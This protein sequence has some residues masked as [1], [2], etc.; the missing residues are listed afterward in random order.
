MASAIVPSAGSKHIATGCYSRRAPP[1]LSPS[2]TDAD[3]PEGKVTQL[4]EPKVCGEV[5]YF[6]GYDAHKTFTLNT[7]SRPINVQ[8]ASKGWHCLETKSL[9]RLPRQCRGLAFM[10]RDNHRSTS[11][12]LGFILKLKSDQNRLWYTRILE[13]GSISDAQSLAA[14]ELLLGD[15]IRF[16][17]VYTVGLRTCSQPDFDSCCI[18]SADGYLEVRTQPT[19]LY[20][21]NDA[22]NLFEPSQT[23]LSNKRSNLHKRLRVSQVQTTLKK[24]QRTNKKLKESKEHKQEPKTGATQN[25]IT[26]FSRASRVPSGM[27]AVEGSNLKKLLIANPNRKGRKRKSLIPRVLYLTETEHYVIAPGIIGKELNNQTAKKISEKLK[28][29]GKLSLKKGSYQC[30]YLMEVSTTKPLRFSIVDDATFD[31]LCQEGQPEQCFKAGENE[32]LWRYDQRSSLDVEGAIVSWWSQEG[33]LHKF[34]KDHVVQIQSAVGTGFGSRISAFCT[35]LNAYFGPRC[36]DRPKRNPGILSKDN[37]C[38][39]DFQ[40]K[41][42]HSS[43]LLLS[44]IAIEQAGT[45]IQDIAARLNPLYMTFTGRSVSKRNIF[46]S[47][48]SSGIDAARYLPI[49]F[50]NFPHVDSCDI[51]H[52]KAVQYFR[53][54]FLHKLQGHKYSKAAFEN[55]IA[56]L[57]VVQNNTGGLG[58]PTTCGHQVFKGDV[59]GDFMELEA[60]FGMMDFSM[61]I[62]TNTVHH[63]YGWAFRHATLVPFWRNHPNDPNGTVRYCNSANEAEDIIV[64]AW[65]K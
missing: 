52:S 27:D 22:K 10:F 30:I 1:F 9:Q 53:D 65:G 49:G 37:I 47:G 28:Q 19:I 25:I 32:Y 36:S 15:N 7:I 46:T 24:Q 63:F 8:D 14:E 39:Q 40:R 57:D 13:D 41:S 18:V 17:N 45:Q 20:Y 16:V 48:L 50:S 33:N 59:V 56:T 44:R 12:K 3:A 11:W 62:T 34:S 29:T 64:V 51:I 5:D 55:G 42:W 26:I 60:R 54:R 23:R 31:C 43:N 58:V 38:S 61:K 4:E 6:F 2:T 35:G 21:K